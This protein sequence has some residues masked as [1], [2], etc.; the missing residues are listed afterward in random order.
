[1]TSFARR[2]SLI[3][4]CVLSVNLC[5]A[6]KATC[7]SDRYDYK[8]AVGKVYGYLLRSDNWEYF[9]DNREEKEVFLSKAEFRRKSRLEIIPL[10]NP[11]KVLATGSDTIQL[12]RIFAPSYLRFTAFL[13][14]RDRP[15]EIIVSSPRKGNP[16]NF[17]AL[18]TFPLAPLYQQLLTPDICL[19]FDVRTAT[20][21]YVKDNS[22]FYWSENKQK[23]EEAVGIIGYRSVQ[24]VT[25]DW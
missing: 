3:F 5:M 12:K 14:Y 2:T 9:S 23:F 1:M 22:Y 21:A 10:M 18:S 19:F 7:I 8:L 16:D 24:H 11:D 13:L 6:Q 25:T 15:T 17:G 4:S 20:F